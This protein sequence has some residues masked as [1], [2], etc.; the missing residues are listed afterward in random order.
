MPPCTDHPGSS[1][2]RARI[3]RTGPLSGSQR[4]KQD[5]RDGGRVGRSDVLECNELQDY[6]TA[7]VHIFFGER[8]QQWICSKLTVRDDVARRAQS[9]RMYTVQGLGAKRCPAQSLARRE[10]SSSSSSRDCLQHSWGTLISAQ[11][12]AAC[13]QRCGCNGAGAAPKSASLCARQRERAACRPRGQGRRRRRRRRG[14]R[15]LQC[16]CVRFRLGY[17]SGQGAK[18]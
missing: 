11:T 1:T 15:R 12:A 5:R 10:S 2:G 9:H 18:N 16:A 13:F 14:R 7:R 8:A 17:T 6:F 4:T 3:T